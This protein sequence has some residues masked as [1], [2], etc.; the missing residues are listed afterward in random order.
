MTRRGARNDDSIA[1]LRATVAGA[2]V[3]VLFTGIG[4]GA[5]HLAG[6]RGLALIPVGLLTGL[7]AG[8]LVRQV[9]LGVASG[10]SSALG[11]F[12]FPTGASV[13]YEPTFSSHDA[14]EAAGDMDGA[15]AAYEATIAGDPGNARAL[16]QAAELH[17][18]A[19]NPGRAVELLLEL[20]RLATG[21]DNE[22]Y[23]TQRLVDL[24][25]GVLNDEGR[26]LVELRRL[27]DRF[28][29]TR[30]GDGAR[31]ALRRLKGHRDLE[32]PP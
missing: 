28:S 7:V 19:G 8:V 20:R 18:R 15:I 24:Y 32:H 31:S 11:A 29:G 2:I 3:G 26:A 16:R 6:V 5:G 9:A 13:P 4:G 30:E 14:K 12:L 10:M 1:R 23:A 21:R 25:L 27:A 22:L 17:A